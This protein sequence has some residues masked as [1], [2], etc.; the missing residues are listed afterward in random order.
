MKTICPCQHAH[1][2]VKSILQMI[3]TNII[4]ENRILK[5]L[6]LQTNSC[7]VQQ[8]KKPKSFQAKLIGHLVAKANALKASPSSK[9]GRLKST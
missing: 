9:A 7:F 2:Q 1:V 4:S 5:K 6:F 8:D 3:Q